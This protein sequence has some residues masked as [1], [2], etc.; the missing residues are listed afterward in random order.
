[1]PPKFPWFP[2]YVSDWLGSSRIAAMTAAQEGAYHRLLCLAWSDKHCSLPSDRDALA[3][4]SK[5]P[6]DQLE[7]ILACFEPHPTIKK[8][9]HNIRLTDEWNKA[10]QYHKERS[11]AG[12]KGAL[13][14]WHGSVI[15]QPIT[16]PQHSQ[17]IL[18]SQSQSQSQKEK[19]ENL[20]RLVSQGLADRT[21]KG[22]E[23]LST[24]LNTMLQSI[25]T[26]TETL[27]KTS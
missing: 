25:A 8:R 17:G 14:L 22:F 2:C 4:M 26:K 11:E 15:T 12:K 7:P 21:T 18:Q 27:D 20:K 9:L 16:P 3:S 1:M 5:L 6:I 13:K 23:P 10:E 24:A 19:K